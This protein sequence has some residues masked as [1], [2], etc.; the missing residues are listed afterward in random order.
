MT[1]NSKTEL[2]LSILDKLFTNLGEAGKSARRL[3]VSFLALL[4]LVSALYFEPGIFGVNT[5]VTRDAAPSTEQIP[6][7]GLKVPRELV[8]KYSSLLLSA[9]Y[10]MVGTYLIHL[11]RLRGELLQAY[12]TL[13]GEL[14]VQAPNILAELTFPSFHTIVSELSTDHPSAF[15]R[16]LFYGLNF[17]KSIVLYVLP[18]VLVLVL[19]GEGTRRSSSPVLTAVFFLAPLMVVATSLALTRDWYGRVLET[20]RTLQDRVIAFV[21]RQE[22]PQAELPADVWKT[23]FSVLG[24][25][26]GVGSIF[27]AL[28][29][30][31]SLTAS[32]PI[33]ETLGGDYVM[34]GAVAA[35]AHELVYWSN[36][37]S[38]KLAVRIPL[39][40]LSVLYVGVGAALA[41]LLSRDPRFAYLPIALGV[42]YLWNDLLKAIV[43]IFASL[44]FFRERKELIKRYEQKD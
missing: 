12:S 15:V 14:S 1:V 25:L 41:G 39:L 4:V 32:F 43:G 7:F 40:L 18:M 42:G 3:L 13:Y 22:Y 10:A 5:Q 19:L 11:G 27:V 30:Y 44:S 9:L 17:L 34:A 29:K 21:K 6:F 31:P 16:G 38:R 33:L 24:A 8:L 35:F 20:A 37:V 26:I 28:W 2:D 36:I 23:V